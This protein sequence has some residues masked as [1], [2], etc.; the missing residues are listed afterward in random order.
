MPRPAG[1]FESADEGL[2]VEHA[3]EVAA[4]DEAP[5]RQPVGVPAAALVHGDDTSDVVGRLD[6]CIGVGGGETHRLLHD[7]VFAGTQQ[8]EG[9]FGVMYRR[10]CDDRDVDAVVGG[11]RR[12]GV[13]RPQLGEVD[14]CSVETVGRI[15]GGGD[16]RKSRRSRSRRVRAGIPCLRTVRSRRRRRRG[17]RPESSGSR[18]GGAG[19]GTG[20]ALRGC[21]RRRAT[22][23]PIVTMRPAPTRRTSIVGRCVN[24][25]LVVAATSTSGSNGSNVSSEVVIGTSP[26]SRTDSGRAAS[27]TNHSVWGS[28]AAMWAPARASAS[29]S[30]G[31]GTRS[32]LAPL[33]ARASRVPTESASRRP[34][35]TWTSAVVGALAGAWSMLMKSQSRKR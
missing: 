13:V 2:D 3:T 8:L 31:S 7:D 18:C 10:R 15:V 27:V 30:P 26:S 12:A 21:R 19:G 20:R 29:S 23:I 5:D 28:G 34:V 6:E 17:R 25:T 33:R 1:V 32:T 14:P 9:E 35:A 24:R 4:F 16:E 11:E 22:V